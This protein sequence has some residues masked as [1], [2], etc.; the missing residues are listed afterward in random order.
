MP[1]IKGVVALEERIEKAQKE[2]V[3]TKQKYDEA[4]ATLKDLLDKR[5]ALKRDALIT[6]IA[7]SSKSYEEILQFINEGKV[8]VE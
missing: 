5:D 8:D 6:A 3:R 7:K 1:S 4:V 2:V